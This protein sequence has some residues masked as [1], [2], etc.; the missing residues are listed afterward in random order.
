M[1]THET[2]TEDQSGATG[3]PDVKEY[4]SF[5]DMPLHQDLLRGIYS[6]GF[7]RP[8][9]I[10]QRAIV[11]L[12]KGGDLVAQSQSGS[13][14]TGAFSIGLLSRINF[15]QRH[16]Q[17]LVL[18][19]TR[20]LTVQTHAVISNIGSYLSGD[21]ASFCELFVGGT[22]VQHDL[23]KSGYM[24]AVGTPGRVCDLLKRGALRT[25]S[26]VTLVL[27]EA[28]EMLSQ[29]FSE[30]LHSVFRAVPREIQ[31]ALFS[32]TMSPDVL[33]MTKAFMRSPTR[34]LVEVADVPLKDIKQ[35]Q[36]VLEEEDKLVALMDL[37]ETASVAQ[38][39]IFANSIQK[40]TYIADQL[41]KE[42]FAVSATHSG[43]TSAERS[44]VMDSFRAGS[45]RVL[46]TTDL[47]ARGL[48]VIHVNI[49]INYDVPRDLAN[50]MHRIGRCGRYGR[51]GV[52]INFVSGRDAEALK[53][54]E[55][56]YSIQIE[57]LQENFADFL[58]T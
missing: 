52:G 34:I 3:H 43:M 23:R 50:Y 49:V 14:K 8:S 2:P 6:Y 44:R 12:H 20:E 37:Y 1:S 57:E 24:I 13:G 39:V 27:D 28:D 55:K 16:V 38:S 40:V 46:V 29:G 7:E 41:N 15:S 22:N 53:C 51:K 45:S 31:V 5:D 26:M 21:N 25:Q 56:H 10:Q 58:Q 35:C 9:A 48:D 18:S 4:A 19:P 30:Q 36:V 11:P 17:G 42:N 32:A 47:N 54:I 33:A